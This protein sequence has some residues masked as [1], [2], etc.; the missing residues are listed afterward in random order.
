VFFLGIFL[1][2]ISIRSL[3]WN[4]PLRYDEGFTFYFFAQKPWFLAISSYDYPNNHI[5]HTILVKVSSFFFGES[6]VVLRLPAFLFGCLLLPLT[7]GYVAKL[8]TKNAAILAVAFVSVSSFLVSYSVNARGYSM[9]YCFFIMLLVLVEYLKKKN[10]VGTWFL[11]IAVQVIGIYTLPTMVYESIVVYFYLFFL[12]WKKDR[13][14]SSL[15]YEK[16]IVSMLLVAVFSVLLYLPVYVFMGAK[17]LVANQY[18]ASYSYTELWHVLGRCMYSFVDFF[19]TDLPLWL[20]ILLAVGI[21]VSCLTY[22]KWR[23]LYFAVFVL[24]FVVIVV[25]RVPPVARVLGFLYPFFFMS[26]A[27]GISDVIRRCVNK[28]QFGAI[29]LLSVLILG[30]G[31]VVLMETESPVKKYDGGPI[32]KHH[33]IFPYLKDR[34]TV[35]DG[36]Y[37]QF[38]MEASVRSYSSFYRIPQVVLNQNVL[39]CEQAFFVINRVLGQDLALSLAK[40]QIDSAAF[41]RD[42]QWVSTKEFEEKTT[43]LE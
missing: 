5:L 13:V 30:N 32:K 36:L 14:G 18:I 27:I 10:T 33:L 40:N 39:K 24:F 3:F 4:G 15:T 16:L 12:L 22:R 1:V 38:P 7:Y 19:T 11:F 23:Y 31:V 6:A 35:N 2:S 20:L 17:P 41:H 37:T 21:G 28:H 9:V 42:F 43:L 26:A 29:L 25:Q 8:F 34:L